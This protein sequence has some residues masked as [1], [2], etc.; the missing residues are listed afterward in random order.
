MVS[1]QHPAESDLVTSSS[2]SRSSGASADLATGRRA[3]KISRSWG[4]RNGLHRSD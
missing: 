3:C 4:L 1:V 2:D